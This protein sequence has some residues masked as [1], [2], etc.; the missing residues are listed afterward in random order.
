M[1]KLGILGLGNM[2][3]SIL[4][5]IIKSNLYNNDEIIIYDLDLSKTNKYFDLGIKLANDINELFNNAAIILLAIKPQNINSLVL[6]CYN[7]NLN[8]ISIVAGKTIN[9]LTSVF[10]DGNYIRVMPNTP[11]LIG[12]GTTV[13]AVNEKTDSKL[14]GETIKIFNSIGLV[15]TI[16]D[17][18]INE[19]IP[20]NGS[21]PAYL[22]YFI[23]CFV[24]KAK[25]LG[26][27][28]EQAKQLVANSIIGS[29]H[30]VL[31]SNKDIDR[32]I[33]DVCS[34][35]GATLKGIEVL[36]NSNLQKTI[37]DVCDSCI[38]RAY[39]LSTK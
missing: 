8:I 31:K 20:L 18:L 2:G 38:K 17:K 22:Y 25:E 37:D 35:G 26:F 28:E 23:K 13:I 33:Q 9:D 1:Y 36:D 10:G 12:E 34:P 4:S 11:S 7:P 19:V 21:M 5:G 3:G 14:L 30:M 15:E 27:G 32:L 16:S 29:A 24:N 6:N 39:E